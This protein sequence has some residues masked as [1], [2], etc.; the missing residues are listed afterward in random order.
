MTQGTKYWDN[1][2]KCSRKQSNN[3]IETLVPGL[4]YCG[5][6]AAAMAHDTLSNEF[7]EPNLYGGLWSIQKEDYV[8]AFFL[9][10]S[11]W[12][13]FQKIRN[14]DFTVWP[15]NEIPQYYPYM[16][17]M[18]F[19]LDA[20]YKENGNF[21]VIAKHVWEGNACQICLKKPG[22]FLIAVA[23]DDINKEIIYNDPWPERFQ[24]GD[25]FNRR[26][27]EV[28]FDNIQNWYIL[29]HKE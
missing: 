2:D 3:A 28:D 17:K 21:E 10:T 16:A 8:T 22:H 7:L 14:L 20:E 25:G 24:N 5:P 1:R 9:D 23:Y 19:G 6:T 12:P 11:N 27:R 18:V 26:L 29:Y 4:E 15:P 13:M